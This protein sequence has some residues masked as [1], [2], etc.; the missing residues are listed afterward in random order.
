MIKYF[1][2]IILIVVLCCVCDGEDFL[3]DFIFMLFVI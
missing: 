2:I 3:V 1:I